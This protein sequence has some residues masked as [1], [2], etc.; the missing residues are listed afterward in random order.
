MG[1]PHFEW[2]YGTDHITVSYG[3]QYEG[4]DIEQLSPGTRGIVLLLLY[5]AIDR[6]DDRPLIIDQPEENL[7]PKSIFDEL[8]ERFRRAKQRRQIIIVTH[9]AELVVN[10]DADQVIV[11]TCGLLVFD[12]GHMIGPGEREVRYEV[13]IQRL[14]RRPDANQ[15]RIVCLSAILPDGEQMEDFSAWLRRDRPGGAIKHD[16]RPTRL[17]FGEVVWNSPTAR[18]N[19][20]VN[21]ERPFVPRFLTGA[22]PPLFIRP[23]KLRTRLFPDNQQELTRNVTNPT[24]RQASPE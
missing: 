24:W 1:G 17:R 12:E 20:R 3:V 18:L 13:Q 7:D 11:A 9:N 15:R 14:L 22:A 23:K 5:L 4:V 10:T 21:E 6:D 8:V 19:L 2:L 16:W